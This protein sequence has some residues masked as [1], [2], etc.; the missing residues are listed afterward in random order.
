MT[1]VGPPV[2]VGRIGVDGGIGFGITPGRS[3][4]VPT[5]ASGFVGIAGGRDSGTVGPALV[6]SSGGN[7]FGVSP[8]EG[9]IAQVFVGR[10]LRRSVWIDAHRNSKPMIAT[11]I[12][13]GRMYQ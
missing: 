10:K 8:T 4:I 6:G 12:E 5:G 13:I 9:S 2:N 1:L 11:T 3:C 7:V